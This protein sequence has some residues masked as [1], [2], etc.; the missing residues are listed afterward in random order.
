MNSRERIQRVLNHE[1]PDRVPI[2]FGAG[3][4]TGLMAST[5]YSLKKHLGLLDPGERIRIV[6][7]YQML[8]EV[9]GKLQ[10]VLG[11]DV[12]GIHPLYNMFGYKNE[13]Y[14]EWTLFDG[15][16]VL[17]PEKF[18]TKPDENGNILMY[19]EGD[20]S[21]PPSGVMPRGGYYFDSVIRQQPIE[22]SKLNYLDNCEEFGLFDDEY[23]LHLKKQVDD[24][25]YNTEKAI[26]LTFPGAGFGDISVVPGPFLK[27]PKGIRDISEWYISIALRPD[28]IKQIFAHQSEI[29][30][31]NLELLYDAVGNKIQVI[32]M[33]GTDFGSQHG[34]MM[35]EKT[36][37]DVFL[38]YQ[39]TLNDWVHNHTSWKTFIHS[40]GSIR[41]LIPSIIEAGFDIL[42][43]VQCS[44]VGM[45]PEEIKAEFGDK[46]V[47]WGGGVDTQNTLPF[48][49]PDEVRLEVLNR[50]DVFR[51]S[52]GFV[53]NAVHNIQAGV[54]AENIM[55]MI[56]A[57][58]QKCRYE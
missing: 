34:A 31:K 22:E 58:N 25:Y 2:D 3:F 1:I 49:N 55:A 48:G 46:I 54:P 9:D 28:Y 52:G 27:C 13:N 15:T 36:Y 30:L 50:M 44:A 7:P 4:Q 19:A 18:N 11:L 57:Y 10:E 14:K 24:I 6:E 41:S 26:Y 8:G 35:S 43:P 33:S 51:S 47:F 5:V 29:A 21:Y 42:N 53:F 17:V 12:K 23:L 39:K 37:K 20:H 40:C 56:E 45:N 32:F 16:P 38:P